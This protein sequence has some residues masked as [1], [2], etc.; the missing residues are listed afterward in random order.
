MLTIRINPD[1]NG[2]KEKLFFG[3]ELWQIGNLMLAFAASIA[4]VILIP[5]I[6]MMKGVL[7]A[8]PAC[9]FVFIAIRPVYGMKGLELATEFVFSLW[10]SKRLIYESE[11]WKEVNRHC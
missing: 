11:E 6:G 1:L 5:D 8:I 3:F 2:V 10:N 7:S 9:P 4:A